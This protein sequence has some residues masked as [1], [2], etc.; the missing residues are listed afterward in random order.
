M[1]LSDI[2][3]IV[4]STT[5]A[6]V[7]RAG[8]GVPM[9]TSFT[10]TWAERFRT[11]TSLSAVAADF[12]ANTPEYLAA[13]AVFGQSPAVAS[14]VIGRCALIPAQQFTVGVQ[15]ANLN[16]PYKLRVAVPTGVVFPSQ[17]A[18]YQ[19]A[20]ATGWVASSI[21]VRGDLVQGGSGAAG[22]QLYACLGPSGAGTSAQFTGF[23]GAVQPSGPAASIQD[24]Q[25]F[26][27]YVGSGSTGGINNDAIMQ[28]LK[29][30]VEFL[31]SPTAIGT[32][33]N[34]MVAAL[35]GAQGARQLTLTANT[36]GKFFG[37]QVYSR[38][39]LTIAQTHADPG[40][41]TDLAAIKL[42]NNSWYG[43]VTTF[44]SEALVDAAAAWVEAN[45]KLYA[46]AV[47]DTA[48]PRVAESGSATDAAHDFKAAAYA[49]SFVVAHPSPDQFADAAEIGKFFPINPGG[50]TWRMK[51]LAGVTVETYS[52]TEQ[53]NMK[54]KYAH[55]YYDIGGRSVVGGDAK[56]GSGEYVD[57][58]RFLD[59]YTANLQADLA[60]LAIGA[61]KIPFTNP[62]I[63]LIE[64]KVRKRNSA[65]IAAGGIAADPA[66]VVVSPDVSTISAADKTN[67]ELSG[68]VTTW[69]LAGAIHHTTVTVT[70]TH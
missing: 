65:G 30:R 46:A 40:I 10:A 5:G 50:E 27:M 42:A 25:V 1:P 13:A 43:L 61:N 33:V 7:T 32:G 8:Y 69:T 48:I 19:S 18:S 9:I 63:A 17:D 68:V 14:I 36:P 52:D 23:G 60:D 41:A 26:W 39:A 20:G 47:M 38:D 11:Y 59:W 57:V 6:G 28:G 49:R 31:A 62:G 64:S 51:T 34:Q 37:A 4:V 15:S 12:A 70:A 44:N 35:A 54:A 3:T 29:A 66:P 67:R 45:T 53:T 2:A 24:G 16:T 56:T 58:T 21:W 55:F 22:P